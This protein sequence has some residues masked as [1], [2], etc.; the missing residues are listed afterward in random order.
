MTCDVLYAVAKEG[1]VSLDDS[2]STYVSGAPEA[3]RVTLGQLCDGTS[4]IGSYASQLMPLWL[5]NPTR[6]W[7]PRELA[8]Y[9]LGQKRTT[10]P[11]AVYVDSDAGYVLLGL[12]LERATRQ[13]RRESH[14]AVRH[15]PARSCGHL[16]SRRRGARLRRMAERPPFAPGRRGTR[17]RRPARH[18]RSLRKRRLHR[19][20]H[21][22]DD[23]RSRPVRAGARDRVAAH[24]GCGPLRPPARR[25][26]RC[27]GVV[28]RRRR[29]PHRRLAHRAGRGHPGLP[30]RRL[31][32]SRD[33]SHRGDRAEQLRCGCGRRAAPRLAARGD[34]IEGACCG[35]RGRSRGGAAVDAPSRITTP[36]RRRRSARSRPSDRS[37]VTPRLGTT[38]AILLVIAG[39]ACQEVGA[40]LGGPPVPDRRS[41]RNGH[42]APRLLG[43]AAAR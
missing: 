10:E 31:L 4:G 3:S 23:R 39:L 28:H 7:N 26:R 2:I 24:R 29:C 20:R 43:G 13:S 15:R 5:S 12:A 33:R 40:S 32:R 1:K 14:P 21:R 17:L 30:V 34:R 6:S 18:H 41:A 37:S 36:S 38:P 22:L 11:G 42:A 9:G 35:G 8:G 19:R 27:P 25:A 16:P